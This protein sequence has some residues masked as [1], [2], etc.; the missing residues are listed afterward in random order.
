MTEAERADLTPAGRRAVI[1]RLERALRAERRRG[2]SG[3]W[4][5]D[6]NR[7]LALKQALASEHA[8]LTSRD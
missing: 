3:H 4:T 7:H 8:G 1:A 6:L 2:I 5:Y